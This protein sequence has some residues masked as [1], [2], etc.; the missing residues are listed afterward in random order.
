MKTTTQTALIDKAKHLSPDGRIALHLMERA[1]HSAMEERAVVRP[2]N[3]LPS[4]VLSAVTPSE[5]VKLNKVSRRWHWKLLGARNEQDQPNVPAL[6]RIAFDAYKKN[7]RM[8]RLGARYSGIHNFR[9]FW[10]TFGSLAVNHLGH[11]EDYRV[12]GTRGRMAWGRLA[13]SHARYNYDRLLAARRR[14]VQ[15]PYCKRL[16]LFACSG[17]LEADTLQDKAFRGKLGDQHLEYWNVGHDGGGQPEIRFRIVGSLPDLATKLVTR[18]G[19]IDA[20]GGHIHINCQGDDRIG[21]IVWYGLRYH[22]S[23]FRF[24]APYTRRHSHWCS[25][26]N[27]QPT[28]EESKHEKYAAVSGSRF[29]AI[30]TVE[31]RLWP[32][33]DKADDWRFRAALMKSIAH[34]SMD[35]ESVGECGFR[36]SNRIDSNMAAV[37]WPAYFA[38]AAGQDPEALRWILKEMRK[39][40][41]TVNNRTPADRIGAARC[42]T[43]VGLFDDSNYRLA[44]Y[45]RSA[46]V[47][48][49]MDLSQCES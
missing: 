45:R 39:K 41:R 6:R 11:D 5:L 25:I 24:L 10:I 16:P 1:F 14:T 40:A 3:R 42:A 31:V 2:I 4:G 32:T 26:G 8:L 36:N 9:D 34:W 20:N 13:K 33:S 22:L 19:N 27:T 46:P 38:W 23:W 17:E 49:A 7:A 44:G 12:L 47:V 35:H 29:P 37:A 28:W 48:P 15:A 43:Y 30:G 21:G 18:R